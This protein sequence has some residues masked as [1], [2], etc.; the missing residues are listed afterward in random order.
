MEKSEFNPFAYYVHYDLTFAN[1]HIT[2]EG[3][4]KLTFWSSVSI[5]LPYAF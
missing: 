4:L 3:L 1:M 5:F 2:I